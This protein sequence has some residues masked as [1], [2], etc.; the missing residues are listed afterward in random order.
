MIGAV[1]LGDG[2]YYGPRGWRVFDEALARGAFLR[3]DAL[4]DT[5][6]LE[7]SVFAS[8]E[9]E[10][11][12]LCARQGLPTTSTPTHSPTRVFARLSKRRSTEVCVRLLYLSTLSDAGRESRL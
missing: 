3:P 12:W 6:K 5:N 11:A 8:D 4:N 1:D 9:Q 7:L 10:Q 2:G